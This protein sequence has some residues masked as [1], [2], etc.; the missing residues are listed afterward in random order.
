MKIGFVGLGIMG[1]PMAKNL[2]KDGYEVICYDFNQSNMDEVAAAGAS[3]A[4]NSQ[5]LANQ[6]DIVITMLPNSPN[7]E[8]ALFS[9]EGIAAGIIEGKIVIDMSSINPVSSQRFAEKLAGL[10][11]E[12][13]DAPVSGGEPKAIDGTIA[14]MVGGK[15]KVFDQCYELLLSMASS[16]TYIG[17]VGA[18][19]I[20][21][22]AN[23]IIVA[24]NIAAVG[25][26][27]S[28]ATKAGADP[29]LVYQGIR[30]GLAG[31]TV[32]DAKSPM[33]LNRDF[34][35]GFRIELHIKDLQN[36]LDTSHMINAGIPLTAQLMEIM[37]VLK[38]D[39]L[40]KKDHSAIA[41]YYE[42]INNLTIESK[43]T[44]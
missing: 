28:F 8:A 33:I 35:P 25:E 22:L 32:M 23:Q 20:A 9:E 6:S 29:E 15:K 40:E 36:A 16:V 1:K 13:L 39:G 37:Q 7:V 44:V 42:K 18:G 2:I 12:F 34:D 30:G 43:D 38:N 17:E 41:C 14:V 11:V 4:K 10:G 24:I 31:S 26:A 5:E 21:K 3:T 27:L 19:N